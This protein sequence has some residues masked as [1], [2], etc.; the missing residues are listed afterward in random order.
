M[1]KGG[2]GSKLDIDDSKTQEKGKKSSP[3]KITK[4]THKSVKM[5]ADTIE[6]RIEALCI[7]LSDETPSWIICAPT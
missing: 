4:K 5:V 7:N 1:K 6:S 3:K 2:K